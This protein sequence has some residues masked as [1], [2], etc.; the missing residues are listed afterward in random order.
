MGHLRAKGGSA[1]QG[2]CSRQG[3]EW[4]LQSKCQNYK[5]HPTLTQRSPKI[6]LHFHITCTLKCQSRRILRQVGL[7]IAVDS[8]THTAG[9]DFAPTCLLEWIERTRL[10]GY[11]IALSF[12]IK[13]SEC[14]PWLDPD[15]LNKAVCCVETKDFL[16][17]SHTDTDGWIYFYFLFKSKFRQPFIWGKINK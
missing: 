12:H 4:W 14:C 16:V 5:L 15:E 17:K 9:K 13:R 11:F 2:L 6:Y 8:K 10:K 1:D 3:D 7:W